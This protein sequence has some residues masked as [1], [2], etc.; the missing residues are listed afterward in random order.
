MTLPPHDEGLIEA[1]GIVVEW[2]GLG[3]APIV[4]VTLNRPSTLNSQT[5]ATWAALAHVGD[6]LPKE[7]RVVVVRGSGGNFSSGLDRSAFDLNNTDGDLNLFRLAGLADNQ[8][9]DQIAQ[10]QR[11]FTWLRS[12]SNIVSI[13]AVD[14]AAVG[15]GF[16]LALACDLR[17]AT[18]TARFS[19]R[20]AALGL[21]P[22]LTGTHTCARL[23]GY[24]RALEICATSRWVHADEAL[25]WGLINA[26][27]PDGD[28]DSALQP[29]VDQL[30]SVSPAALR[31][32]KSL[33][34]FAEQSTP[35][36]QHA[37]ERAA[38]VRIIKAMRPDQL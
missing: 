37:H 20:E 29:L 31:E 7:T 4:T 24:A 34:A 18:A 27:S 5:A 28:L 8:I 16:Q 2:S 26:L 12:N 21:V 19:M 25:S 14:G 10:F 13:A 30:L 9:D 33:M 22:D 38:Q 11:G 15:A 1:G 23:I 36:Q 32:I 17:V 6:C 3:G 35:D